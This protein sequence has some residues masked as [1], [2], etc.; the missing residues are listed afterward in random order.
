MGT[1]EAIGGNQQA[2]QREG[3]RVVQRPAL[4]AS[5]LNYLQPL[6]L[7]FFLEV[8]VPIFDHS[9]YGGHMPNYPIHTHNPFIP[10]DV[11]RRCVFANQ[12]FF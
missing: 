12:R 1:A 6:Q 7:K 4:Q 5:L 10:G 3:N 9:Y 2:V 11:A 8:L